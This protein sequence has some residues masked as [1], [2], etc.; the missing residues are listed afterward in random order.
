MNRIRYHLDF[1][2]SKMNEFSLKRLLP[3]FASLVLSIASFMLSSDDSKTPNQSSVPDRISSAI[4]GYFRVVAESSVIN[5]SI[6]PS[7]CSSMLK[8]P[9]GTLLLG[10]LG[11]FIIGM[12]KEL[13]KILLPPRILSGFAALTI[14]DTSY[15]FLCK[16]IRK[17]R[18]AL[19]C[20]WISPIRDISFVSLSCSSFQGASLYI[21]GLLVEAA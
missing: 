7:F 17:K 3:A 10:K 4:F 12:P 14:V 15:P 19:S 2:I 13:P 9:S 16:N 21:G 6:L 11:F 8:K 1:V 18:S 5:S 20:A